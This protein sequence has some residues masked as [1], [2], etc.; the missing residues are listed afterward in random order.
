MAQKK[1]SRWYAFLHAKCPRCH[2]GDMFLNKNPY[3]FRDMSKMPAACPV[4]R[5]D[6]SPETGFYWGAMYMSYGL[7]IFS[8]ILNVIIIGLIFG[9]E[10]Y[11]LIIGNTIILILGFPLFFRY[12]R[13]IWLHLNSSFSKEEF[14]KAEALSH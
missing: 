8:S 10:I 13:V 7:T 6:Y 9:F 14:E 2:H 12:S 4:C 3:R 5:L 11:P 1:E